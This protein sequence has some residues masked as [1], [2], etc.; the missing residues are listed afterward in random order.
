MLSMLAFLV[1][2]FLA[3]LLARALVSG[4]SPTGLFGTTILGIVG[5][6]VGGFLGYV[7]FGK[8]VASG[9]IQAS[10]FIGSVIGAILVLMVYKRVRR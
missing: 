9:S 6:F 2:G 8:D 4:K 7:I 3:G 1:V 10:G 5:S